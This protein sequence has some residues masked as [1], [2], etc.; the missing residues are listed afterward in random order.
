[1]EGSTCRL[2]RQNVDVET[3]GQPVHRLDRSEQRPHEGE[4]ARNVV[5]VFLVHLIHGYDKG[6]DASPR[7]QQKEIAEARSAQGLSQPALACYRSR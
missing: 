6:R 7:R 1:M 2:R 4:N 5:F 3:L